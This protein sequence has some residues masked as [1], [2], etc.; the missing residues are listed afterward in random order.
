[1]VGRPAAVGPTIHDPDPR[2]AAAPFPETRDRPH[3]VAMAVVEVAG[4]AA[5]L[6]A[7]AEMIGLEA[8]VVVAAAAAAVPAA[9]V[10]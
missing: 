9:R 2:R 4:V 8:S 5:S 6:E 3:P 1:M 10:L 7:G